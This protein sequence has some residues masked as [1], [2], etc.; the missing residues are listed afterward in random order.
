MQVSA[1]VGFFALSFLYLFEG[2]HQAKVLQTCKRRS[3]LEFNKIENDILH[4]FLHL[5]E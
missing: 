1:N 5:V 4:S 2:H 3:P